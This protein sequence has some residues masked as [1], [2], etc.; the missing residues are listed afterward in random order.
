M[1]RF[2]LDTGLILGFVRNAPWALRTRSE[3]RLAE[4]RVYTSVICYGEILALA[5]RRGWGKKT[6]SRLEDILKKIPTLDINKQPVIHAYARIDTWT[7]GRHLADSEPAP[8]PRKAVPMKQ[9]DLLIYA[10]DYASKFT[11]VSTDKYFMHLNDIW[12]E[13]EYVDQRLK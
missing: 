9:N 3:L 10:T 8:L 2:L 4:A 12:I 1:A 7:H 11:L 6:R 13:L 5:E